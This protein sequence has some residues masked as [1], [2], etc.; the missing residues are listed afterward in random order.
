MKVLFVSS[1]T[2][3]GEPSP[4]VKAQAESLKKKSVN[5]QS[6][7][8]NKK[9]FIGYLLECLRLR[10]H[11]KCQKI[12]IIHAHYGLSAIAGLIAR[13]KEKLI[14]S[15]MGDDLVGTN[16]P[17]GKIS[18]VSLM[19]SR[20]NAWL[21]SK[22]YNYSIVKSKEMLSH[23]GTN[24]TSLVP[25]GV[26]IQLFRPK[27]KILCRK[28]LGLNLSEK[29]ALFVSDPKR[30]EKNY[31]LAHEATVIADIP[32]FRL[33]TIKDISQSVLPDYY[34]AA[35]LLIL[36]SFHEGSPNVIKEAMA[37]NCPIVS[38]DVG[39]VR[40][41]LGD[42]R[43]CWL[44]SFDPVDVSKKIQYALDFALKTG[45]TKGRDR[46]KLLG[47]YSDTIAMKII[48]IYQKVLS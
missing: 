3:N 42:V 19:L 37:C 32:S 17:D 45:R 20:L 24:R 46:I 7:C 14:V 44:A 11:L 25:N 26:D 21:A 16:L 40:E 48:D 41:V 9:G 27:D 13:R 22:F 8:I 36:S 6:F 4:I 35:D 2:R 23:L 33:M 1:G 31:K 29:I 28:Q 5:V 15:F 47:F 18:E 30:V 34:S 12:N 10:Q 39:D 38:T 43:G